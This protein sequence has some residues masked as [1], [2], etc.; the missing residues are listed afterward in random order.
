MGVYLLLSILLTNSV[1]L[2]ALL[3]STSTAMTV[4]LIFVGQSIREYSM[5]VDVGV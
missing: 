1:F 5:N 3:E 2:H 4:N